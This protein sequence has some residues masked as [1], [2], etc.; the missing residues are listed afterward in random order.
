MT[1]LYL[2]CR[3]GILKIVY[4]FLYNLMQ[5]RQVRVGEV[6]MILAGLLLLSNVY[7]IAATGDFTLWVM[8]KIVYAA[9]LLF[10]LFDR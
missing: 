3:E 9:G 4:H 2:R 7:I 8:T 10:L 6:L 1:A 5:W